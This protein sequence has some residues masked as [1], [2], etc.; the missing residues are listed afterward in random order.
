[1]QEIIVEKE[2]MLKMPELLQNAIRALYLTGFGLILS[3]VFTLMSI[4]IFGI[5]SES[6]YFGMYLFAQMVINFLYVNENI[7]ILKVEW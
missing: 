7:K 1:M 3:F 4:V 2:K 5:Q 6:Y